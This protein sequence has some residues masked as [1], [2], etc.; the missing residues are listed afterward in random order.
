[1]KPRADQPEQ[2]PAELVAEL[3]GVV[4]RQFYPDSLVDDARAKKIR[5]SGRF[6]ERD[7]M[8]AVG[9]RGFPRSTRSCSKAGSPS[10]GD[11]PEMRSVEA[12]LRIMSAFVRISRMSRWSVDEP[13]P[14]SSSPFVALPS[15]DMTML[16]STYGRSGG[17]AGSSS[18]WY[19]GT[20][21][22]GA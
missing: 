18:E 22:R 12:P 20:V 2:T 9:S 16:S 11:E 4:R 5:S 14:R 10:R 3:L 7:R 15:A 21:T 13:I 1:M 8:D 19:I 6:P 17:G